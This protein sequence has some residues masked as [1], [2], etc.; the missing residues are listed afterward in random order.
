MIS[1]ENGWLESFFSGRNQLKWND[2]INGSLLN[3]WYQEIIPWVNS[4]EKDGGNILLV[5]PCV[6]VKGEVT[7]YAGSN[8]SRGYQRL[9][10]E[11]Q[12]FIGCSYSNFDMTP[13]AIDVEDEVEFSFAQICTYKVHKFTASDERKVPEI[14]RL[15]Q[16]YQALINQL[17]V[18]DNSFE[19]SFSQIRGEFDRALLVSDE[20][21][22]RIKYEQLINTGRLSAENRKFLELR[23]FAG[24]GKW[25]QIAG[26]T[27]L[28]RSLSDLVLPPRVLLDV[29]EAIYRVFVLPSEDPKD[30]TSALDAFQKAKLN[31]YRQLFSSRRELKNSFVLKAFF[32]HELC[33]ERPVIKRLNLLHEMLTE[34]DEGEFALSLQKLIPI[35]LD[36]GS[37]E[38][39]EVILDFISDADAAFNEGDYEFALDLYMELPATLNRLKKMIPCAKLIGDKDHVKKVVD[40]IDQDHANDLILLSENF[41]KTLKELIQA[42][43]NAGDKVNFA[44]T[45]DSIEGWLQWT[46]SVVLGLQPGEA[47]DILQESAVKWDVNI[48]FREPD[49][50]NELT[51]MIENADDGA[52][53][54]FRAAYFN[55]FEA[56]VLEERDEVRELKPLL[57]ILLT[58]TVLFDRPSNDELELVRQIVSTLVNIGLSRKEYEELIVDLDELLSTQKSLSIVG[59]SLDIMEVLTLNSCSSVETRL[60]FF[61]SVLDS[62]RELSHRLFDVHFL[63]IELLSKDLKYE[64]PPEFKKTQDS[65]EENREDIYKF[66]E[67]KKIGIYTL[68]EQ[69]GQRAS[70]ILSK[71]CPSVLIELNH[72]KVCSN[73]LSNLAKSSDI[74]V[75]AWKSSKHQAFYCIKDNRPSDSPLL[76]PLGKGSSSIVTAV[77]DLCIGG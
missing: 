33:R 56:F 34:E 66:L 76:Q 55:L 40:I 45:T 51:S 77:R 62:V 8:N 19:R 60:R 30:P 2:L 27:K 39:D 37:K 63:S 70:Q 18:K 7:W 17:D 13:C 75:F 74:F 54:I 25:S 69:A 29:I 42:V 47:L 38:G 16:T 59:W 73:K 53:S 67:N 14:R 61:I 3:G 36:S 28:L 50:L 32:F 21:Q 72:D 22:A 12:A 4:L 15:L 65:L 31:R 11:L 26:N 68:T 6:S 58:N 9:T 23:L 5:L 57:N 24:L 41:K 35:E 46:N 48:F 1:D 71:F 10:E 20:E 43:S 44:K 52:A 49:K 64:L